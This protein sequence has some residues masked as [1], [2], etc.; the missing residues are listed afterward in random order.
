MET[1]DYIAMVGTTGVRF[2]FRQPPLS[3]VSNI[4]Y[5]PFT[6]RV[7]FAILICI[8]GCSLFLYV[9]SKW[10]ATMGMVSLFNL[11]CYYANQIIRCSVDYGHN[12]TMSSIILRLIL[13]TN[14][15][16]TYNIFHYAIQQHV[17]YNFYPHIFSFF[18]QHPLQLD[19]SWADVLILIIGAVLQQGCTLEPRYA[20]GKE[21][22]LLINF[23][24]FDLCFL[25]MSFVLCQSGNEY[26]SSS[27]NFSFA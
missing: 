24:F 22:R 6:A 15:M 14:I 26:L 9:T 17:T 16:F 8:L 20:A 27:S 12:I 4:F 11:F 25:F 13:P 2:V 5:L 19:G 3:Y 18:L 23:L 7:W 10:E 21:L 1:V